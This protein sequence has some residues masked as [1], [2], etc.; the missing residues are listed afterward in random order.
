MERPLN[1]RFA[2]RIAAAIAGL[3]ALSCIATA[4]AT[5][6][7]RGS[8]DDSQR[9]WLDRLDREDR[10]ALDALVGFAAPPLPEKGLWV[11]GQPPAE[12]RGKVVL[13][14]SFTTR[15]NGRRSVELLKRALG[16]RPASDLVV[17]LVHTPDN[18]ERAEQVFERQPVPYPCLVDRDGSACDQFGFFRRPTNLLIDRQGNVRLAGLTAEG[19]A[20]AAT[21]L[22]AESFDPEKP[23]QARP[24]PKVP[25]VNF[26]TFGEPVRSASDRRGQQA[27]EFVVEQWINGADAPRGRLLLVDFWATWCR[28]CIAALPRMKEIAGRHREDICVIGISSET[29][30]AFDRG[31]R[32][33]NLDPKEFNYAIAIDPQRR[34][35]RPFHQARGG[36]AI[37]HVVVISGDGVVRWQGH[38]AS[39]S[40]QV[41]GQ[42]IAANQP[43]RSAGGGD[44]GPPPRWS[45]SRKG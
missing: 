5:P 22:L 30:E 9:Q 39:L 27:P 7:Q 32:G 23:P 44:A 3:A 21:R 13:I 4:A 16:D 14:Q 45:R 20:S 17:L 33:L 37:P 40:D 43:L 41:L 29:S 12:L 19:A 8:A 25:E 18:A 36:I 42:L 38:P 31:M 26:P 24:Q 35:E 34:F 10:A 15:G 1:R 28:P 2:A 11:G 6:P